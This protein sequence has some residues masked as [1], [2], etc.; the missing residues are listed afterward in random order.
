MSSKRTVTRRKT[1][2]A[3]KKRE[4][5]DPRFDN[6]SG[7]LNE[8]AFRKNYRFLEEY[9]AT[10]IAELRSAVKRE[11]SAER[12]SD[13][14]ALLKRMQQDR[15]ERERKDRVQAKVREKR[16]EIRDRVRKGGKAFHLKKSAIRQIELEDKFEQLRKSGKLQSYMEKKRKRNASKDRRALPA[17]RGED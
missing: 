10:E 9:E 3:S 5:R 1:V 8:D 14:A 16:R 17:R 7:F 2:V 6:A 12:R 13:M 4:A 15:A 11:R